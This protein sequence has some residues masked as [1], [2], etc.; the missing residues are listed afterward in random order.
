MSPSLS[1]LLRISTGVLSG[2]LVAFVCYGAY[3]FYFDKP[4]PIVNNQTFAEGSKPV[5]T[6]GNSSKDL[7]LGMVA[8]P[9]FLDNKLGGFVGGLV[10]YKF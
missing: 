9:L 10:T 6:Q 1:S 4:I 7:S 5:I 3:R 8:G 2:V